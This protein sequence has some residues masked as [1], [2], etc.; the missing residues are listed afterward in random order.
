MS[1]FKKE[2]I[3]ATQECGARDEIAVE[4][5][6]KRPFEIEAQLGCEV[7]AADVFFLTTIPRCELLKMQVDLKLSGQDLTTL[8]DIITPT[9]QSGKKDD[10]KSVE[11]AHFHALLCTGED[12]S[13]EVDTFIV[14]S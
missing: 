2:L 3:K 10:T 9:F 8:L 11:L 1:C 6:I 7:D 12:H 5:I 4:W 14:I 13:T